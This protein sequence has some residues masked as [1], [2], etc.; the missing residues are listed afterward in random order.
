MSERQT[1]WGLFPGGDPR[2]FTPE[3]STATEEQINAWRFDCAAWD[4]A[5]ARGEIL[6]GLPCQQTNAQIGDTD[7]FDTFY[8]GGFFYVSVDSVSPESEPAVRMSAETFNEI[9]SMPPGKL[10]FDVVLG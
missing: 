5:E 4:A 10:P 7:H 6:S 3:K 8:G 1:K 2:K 9:M